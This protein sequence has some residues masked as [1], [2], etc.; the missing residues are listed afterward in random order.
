MISLKI[1]SKG[2]TKTDVS[3]YNGSSGSLFVLMKLLEY[4]KSTDDTFITDKEERLKTIIYLE[5]K[6]RIALTKNLELLET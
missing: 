2:E 1:N 5:E 4:F 3:F 6:T